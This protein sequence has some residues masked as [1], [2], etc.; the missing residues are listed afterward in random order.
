M[1]IKKF[2]DFEYVLISLANA[3]GEDKLLFE[4]RIQWCVNQGKNIYNLVNEADD[5]ALF[6]R[7]LIELENLKKGIT[8]S[9]YMM[10]LD[11]TASGLQCLA[12]L[13]GCIKTASNVGLVIPHKRCDVYTA[14]AGEMNEFLPEYAHIQLK[15]SLS[16]DGF[17]RNDLKQPLMTHYYGS[18]AIP[19]KVF[20]QG[21]YLNAFYNALEVM[22]PGAEDLMRDFMGAINPK[23]THYHWTMPDGFEVHCN[24]IA[25]LEKTIEIQELLNKNGNASTI[26]HLYK[27]IGENPYYVSVP[28][29][30]THSVDS[31]VL[32]EMHRR[33]K[34]DKKKLL[35][36]RGALEGC[37]VTDKSKFTSLRMVD[38]LLEGREDFTESQLGQLAITIDKVLENESAPMV[39]IHDEFKSYPR[40]MNTMRQYYVDIMGEV[41]DSELATQMLRQI[42]EDPTIVYHKHSTDLSKYIAEAQYAIC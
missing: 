13:S 33:M 4:D 42:Y 38:W 37:V 21:I 19:E 2:T 22:N 12:V 14:L 35:K 32:R 18:A 9:G 27:A 8:K 40:M 15:K 16:G 11:G 25:E 3:F 41:A 10:G 24:V 31:F 7:G 30:A 20:G 26:T 34:H 39:T 17:T 28:A 23:R 29:N 1:A 6:V 36:V 5:K